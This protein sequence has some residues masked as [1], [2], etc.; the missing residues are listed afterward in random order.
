MPNGQQRPATEKGTPPGEGAGKNAAGGAG[1]NNPSPVGPIPEDKSTPP[2]PGAGGK[3]PE[4][5]GDQLA[6]DSGQK[7]LVI[8]TIEKM[9]RENKVTPDVE[10]QLG[11]TKE[12]L[13]Q[14]VKKYEKP[15]ERPPVGPGREIKVK[16]DTPER[17]FNPDRKAPEGL[18]N[19]TTSQRNQRTGNASLIDDVSGLSEGSSSAAPKVYQKRFEAYKSSLAQPGMSPPQSGATAP[20]NGTNK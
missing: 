12:Q 3:A 20:A 7:P 8:Q 11:F 19:V 17:K 10:K 2:P 9:L 4:N 16:T 1:K 14:F 15:K 6:P 5:P 13:E 18:Q